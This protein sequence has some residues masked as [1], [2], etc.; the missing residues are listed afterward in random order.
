MTNDV[1]VPQVAARYR[2]PKSQD[3]MG[4]MSA[5]NGCGECIVLGDSRFVSRGVCSLRRVNFENML[6]VHV[7]HG[8]GSF[9]QCSAK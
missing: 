6:Q 5:I 1:T 8:G 3:V 7:R 2:Q 9:G 4:P